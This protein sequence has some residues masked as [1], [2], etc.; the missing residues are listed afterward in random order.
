MEVC[1]NNLLRSLWSLRNSDMVFN[2]SV[3]L[4]GGLVTLWDS[5]FFTMESSVLNQRYII[6]IGT[7]SKWGKK[8]C[9]VNLYAPND[10]GERKS[11]FEQL[12]ATVGSLDLP[13]IVGGNFNSIMEEDEKLGDLF[14]KR[15]SEIL[16]DFT[17]NLSLINLPLQGGSFT[18]FG[19]KSPPQASRIDRFCISP[20]LLLLWP[21]LT[22]SVLPKSLS[23]HCPIMISFQS[24]CTP[25][26]PFKWFSSWSGIKGYSDAINQ[27]ISTASTL[28][29]SHILKVCKH[30]SKQWHVKEVMARSDNIK[31]TELKLHTL[32]EKIYLNNGNHSELVEA[33]KLRSQLWAM[34]RKEERDWL[35]KSRL[36]W[37]Q[38]GDRNTRFFHL[39][40]TSRKM[41]NQISQISFEGETF[42]EPKEISSIFEQHFKKTFQSRTT[43][44]I[45]KWDCN[46][47]SLPKSSAEWL[48]RPF[49]KDE[50]WEAIV[51]ADGSRAPG[52]DG[53]N[54]QFF[55][56]YWNSLHKPIMEFFNSFYSGKGIPSE[57][58]LAYVALIPKVKNPTVVDDFRPISLVGSLYKIVARVLAR[59][60][61]LFMSNLISDCQFAF[62]KGRQITDCALIANELVD[63]AKKS[64]EEIVIFK[65]DFKKA[66]DSIEWPFLF[67]VMNKMGFGKKWCNW[68][69]A[70]VTTSSLV[71]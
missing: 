34:Y 39:T 60:M 20:D 46:L 7:L 19:K 70:C 44:R 35:Q 16:R 41:S 48:E 5:N 52:P 51:S 23:D 13:I 30:T 42:S 24:V 15:A 6:L 57:L 18:W 8:V 32:E 50:V 10:D 62:I 54:L 33:S 9:V 64:K 29:I 38:E 66:F 31:E 2:P 28:G 45:R 37:F 12:A 63:L 1:R 71:V 53:F 3:G 56:N 67:L 43:L 17:E 61:S 14:N 27:A 55:K 68:I 69:R 26:K 65:A 47:K 59:R 40:A 22:Q 36:K 25:A 21:N 4:A 49:S 58:N 11:F